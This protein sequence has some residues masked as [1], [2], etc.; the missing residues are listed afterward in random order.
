MDNSRNKNLI[1]C[2]SNEFLNSN[3][4][5][6]IPIAR[7]WSILLKAVLFS[8]AQVLYPAEGYKTFSRLDLN[9]ELSEVSSDC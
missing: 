1:K 5:D 6:T 9:I 3:L 8:L 4:S 2:H 7:Y